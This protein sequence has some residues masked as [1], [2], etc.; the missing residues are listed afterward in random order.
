VGVGQFACHPRPPGQ[1]VLT[2]GEPPDDTPARVTSLGCLGIDATDSG[3]IRQTNKTEK[4]NGDADLGSNES[5]TRPTMGPRGSRKDPVGVV[6]AGRC[7]GILARLIKR[8]RP[9]V[10]RTSVQTGPKRVPN[11]SHAD[12]AADSRGDPDGITAAG[13]QVRPP[14]PPYTDVPSRNTTTWCGGGVDVAWGGLARA[15]GKDI[16]AVRRVKTSWG[17]GVAAPTTGERFVLE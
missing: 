17:C 15:A 8:K 12:L 5:Q 11:E 14:S 9:V 13:R 10:T 2:L 7:A 4:A 6:A 3:N 16:A 1:G